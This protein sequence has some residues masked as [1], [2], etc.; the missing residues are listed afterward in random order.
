[1]H[2]RLHSAWLLALALVGCKHVPTE[3]E[4]RGAEL[5]YEIGLQAQPPATCRR[6]TRRWRSRWRWIRT[7]R[8]R[9]T[10]WPS[11]CTWP[12]TGPRRPSS[13]TRRR[14]SS[15][16]LLRGQDEPG[17]RVPV[18]GA[19][20][21]GHQAVRA[22]PQRHALPHALHRAGQHGLGALQEGR[23]GARAA[24]H[25]GLGDDQPRL[26]PGLQEPGRHLRGDG[27]HF[28]RVP[29]LRPLPG[30]LPGRGGC[31]PAR[32]RLPGEAGE[33]GRGA[34]ELHRLRGQGEE[35]RYLKDDCHRL[36]EAL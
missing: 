22:V 30:G 32:G 3:Q 33:D 31:L 4:R 15:A 2:R 36:L 5:R 25:Q 29:P 9:T 6:P 1:M 19:L 20:R 28:R 18:P 27:Q 34:A 7:T 17:Q 26:L 13:T 8:R 35:R 23:D 14:W 10:P 21:R 11:S 16:R 12:S 24:E